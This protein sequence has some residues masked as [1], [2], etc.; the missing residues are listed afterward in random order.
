MESADIL[1]DYFFKLENN[2]ELE[3]GKYPEAEELMN[4]IKDTEIWSHFIKSSFNTIELQDYFTSQLA[5][6]RSE[7]FKF[8]ISC[9]VYFVQANFT[10]PDLSED[11]VK[12]L[13]NPEFEAVD[14]F[15]LL[16]VNHEEINVNTKYPVLLVIA[17][18]IFEKCLVS[19][20]VNTLWN[21]RSI[22]IHQK[23]MDELSPLL[24]SQADA[25]HKQIDTINLQGY[26][27]AKFD[28]EFAQL[29][30]TFRHVF[31]A[32][33][34]IYSADEILGVQY[35]LRGKLGKRTKYQENDI[36][37]LTLEISLVNN[38]D[39]KRPPVHDFDVPQNVLLK[40]D[41]RLESIAFAEGPTKVLDFPNT[42]QKLFLTRV[43]EIL[44]AK[45]A[46]DLQNEELQPF[47]D[48][49]LG[50]KNT[51]SVRVATL[52]L[53]CKLEVKFRRTIERTLAQCRE[54]L[55][56]YERSTPHVLNRFADVFSTGLVPM[57]SVET[58]CAD[59]LLTLGL[60]KHALDIYK[61]IRLWDEVIVCYTL[62]KLRHKAAEVIRE[63]LFAKETVKMW[64]WLGDA[65]DDIGCYEKAWILSRKRSH[66]AQRHWGNF[67]Y[68][69]KEYQECIPHF[70][71][72]LSINPLQSQ[73][74]L[75]LGF[76]ALQTEN[77]QV[78]ATAYRRYTSLEPDGFQAWNNLAQAYIKIGNKR[79]A[80]HA[81]LESLKYNFENWKIWENLLV[82]SCDILYLSNIIKAYHRLLDLKG[83][84]LNVDALNVL[85]FNVC[86]E[87]SEETKKPEIKRQEESENLLQKTR[88][89][90]GRVTAIYP[91]EGYVWEMYACLVPP[92]LLRA[93]RL[94]RAFRG[95]TQ[96][97][98]DK[99][100]QTCVQVMCLCVK[101]ADIVLTAGIDAQNTL[102]NS[103][104]LN[105][106][107]AIAAIKKHDWEE[108]RSL[109]EEVSAHLEKLV[110]KVK[111][112]PEKHDLLID[113]SIIQ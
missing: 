24:L 17:K 94:Q 113:S 84:Y 74:W 58:Q 59:V 100:P 9:F 32:K 44:I 72:S 54:I 81:L 80:H 55:D 85:V 108:T 11:I 31:K 61:K 8:G 30:L 47:I 87:V 102:V 16:A 5:D 88:E 82:V 76:A 79:G 14:F 45:P 46:D 83:K 26:E 51:W 41:V 75:K 62:L 48:L 90:L 96:P 53:R 107:S 52:L 49:I 6:I 38:S 77:W 2:K 50:Q 65:T 111:N 103:V 37:Q 86:N 66:R 101:L 33:E 10:G 19:N 67:L 36:A 25:L 78:A 92:S 18:C 112:A 97:G 106:S 93:Q 64:C 20:T 63:Q 23:I 42:E 104:K 34:H 35:N 15:K 29:Y 71:K 3:E 109:V 56:S 95:Y 73:V 110:E 22:I 68:A 70:E 60:V 1:R 13:E 21:W 99:N 28:I 57:W 98:W 89:L 12:L 105:L 43:H 91:G 4:R 40:D 7:I 27:K 39:L 69:R